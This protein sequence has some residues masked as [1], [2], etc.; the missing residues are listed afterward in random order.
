MLLFYL[1]CLA[2][3]GL[4]PQYLLWPLP[5]LLVT[6]RLGLAA[7]YTSVGTLFLLLYYSN[8]W[9]SFYAS[10]NLGVFA[11]LRG[12]SWLLPPAVLESRE[13]LPMVHALG[14]VA[15]P[16]CAMVVTA[17]VFKSGCGRMAEEA[18]RSGDSCCFS[19]A[20]VWHAAALCLVFATI[21]LTRLTVQT[22]GHSR[23]TQIWKTLPAEYGLHIRSLDPT[24]VLVRD[25]AG[26]ASLNVVVLLAL[27]TA[28]W[29]V[30][31]FPDSVSGKRPERHHIA[32]LPH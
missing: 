8:P 9:T 2:T 19:S 1:C 15:F 14:N 30:F 26:F 31:C 18:N 23:L 27:F 4:S 25:S 12:L 28:V 11:P 32:T 10:E 17:L 6:N 13:L 5:L 16:C 21:L 22:S 29:C 24:V 3:T 20:L 7:F